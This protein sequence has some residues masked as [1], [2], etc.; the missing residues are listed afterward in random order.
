MKWNVWRKN[1][2]AIVPKH[3]SLFFKLGRSSV[4]G[5]FC[6]TA[7]KT[8]SLTFI[9][10]NHDGCSRINSEV[11]QNILPAILQINKFNLIRR[12]FMQYTN[13]QK[14]A[15]TLTQ[16]IILPPKEKTEERNLTKLKEAALHAQKPP[17]REN[18]TVCEYQLVLSLMRLM[19]ASK[20]CQ[21]LFVY[22]KTIFSYTFAHL[23]LGWSTTKGNM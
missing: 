7:F 12:T 8:G 1:D 2:S 23:Q 13:D 4:I 6:M 10:V 15:Q 17:L 21:L 22:H 14:H 5:L 9:N 3:T 19:Q 20:C 16:L 11:Y 18:A